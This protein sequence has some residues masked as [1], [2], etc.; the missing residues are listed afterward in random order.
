MKRVAAHCTKRCLYSLMEAELKEGTG[1]QG[2]EVGGGVGVGGGF[3]GRVSSMVF[4]C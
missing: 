3:T 2:G 4:Q 1:G